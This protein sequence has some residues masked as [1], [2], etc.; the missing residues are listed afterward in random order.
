MSDLIAQLQRYSLQRGDFILASGAHSSYYLD[1]RRTALTAAGAQEIGREAMKLAAI[2]APDAVGCGGL[3]LGADPIITAMCVAAAQSNMEWGGVIVR[4]QAK[5]HGTQK[6]VEVAGNLVGNEEI[7]AVDDVVTS[8]GST[9]EA[10]ERLREYGFV[11]RHAI[12]VV[13][14]EAGGAAALAQHGVTLHSLV[15]VSQ[16]LG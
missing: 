6:S 7:I 11:V 9:I 10:I 14:R 3:T 2:V 1:V 15:S 13:D 5:S 8:A 16:L 12:C 4:K